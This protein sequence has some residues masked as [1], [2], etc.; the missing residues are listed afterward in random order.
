MTEALLSDARHAVGQEREKPDVTA[1]SG[2]VPPDDPV[3]P[4]RLNANVHMGEGI[5]PSDGIDAD[6]KADVG[7]TSL[8]SVTK[9]PV[10]SPG[11]RSRTPTVSDRETL[12]GCSGRMPRANVMNTMMVMSGFDRHAGR[13]AREAD[14]HVGIDRAFEKSSGIG[15]N[16]RTVGLELN[17]GLVSATRIDR[18]NHRR[19]QPLCKE[20]HI[21]L[22]DERI[23]APV[24]I[25]P[26]DVHAPQSA[27][28]EYSATVRLS[29]FSGSVD[30]SLQP[31]CARRRARPRRKAKGFGRMSEEVDGTR[32]WP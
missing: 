28:P 23:G 8:G 3:F 7:R 4:R 9:R 16:K 17:D 29:G 11:S 10:V 15:A 2:L 6:A 21:L 19:R 22:H 14:G 31:S 12:E 20:R 24:E 18:T 13:V 25:D 1:T 5:D 32:R 27:G 26:T 30:A